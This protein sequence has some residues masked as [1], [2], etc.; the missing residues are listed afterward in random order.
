MAT[1]PNLI[2]AMD[3]APVSRFHSKAIFVSGMGFFTDAYD[4]FIIGT[5]STLISKQWHLGTSQ[6]ALINSMTLL[7]AFFGAIAWGRLADVVGRKR[8]YGLEAL[9]M[10]V[11]ALAS[12][13]APSFAALVAFRFVLGLGV[14][15]DY[16]VSAVLMSEYSNRADRGRLVG[17]VFAMQALG[18]VSGYVAGLALLAAGVD[19]E[20]V[21]RVLLGL[22]ALPSAA[23]L[24]SRR[25]MPESPRFQA[26]VLG[27]EREAVES[28]AAYSEGA[29]RAA[30]NGRALTAP[31]MTLGRFLTDR[32][33][34]LTL[35][36]T[37]GTW[38]VFDYAYYGNSVSAPLIVKTVLG[39]GATV[40]QS[41]ALNL[42]VF[43]VAA[44]PGYYLACAF[45]D[46]IGHRRLQLIGF[47]MMGVMFLLIGVIPGVTGV[48]AP[49]LLLFGAS[50]FFAEFGPNTTTFVLAAECFPTSVRTTG[51]GISAGVAKLGAFI[52]VY[53]FPH[54][55]K[56]FG[57]SGALEFSA[58]MAL[59][60]TVLTLAIPET[61][62]RSLEQISGE[63]S[64]AVPS[65]TV[66]QPE[67]A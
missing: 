1:G 2:Q 22:G 49:F 38:F 58:G 67:P 62:Q 61:S 12:A 40:E 7:G 55:T 29:V 4:L 53:L 18:T 14:G 16:P 39:K 44:V 28:L 42:I 41:L 32:R 63:I 59:I 21:W 36:G 11:F 64:L 48:V 35:L 9:I 10:L 65:G 26:W 13:A 37:A 25:R 17:L 60:G 46:R 57:V 15:G 20:V 30:T 3:E 6:T 50:Y 31:R 27:R 33:M 23:V 51:H 19:H 34:M 54:L 45:M 52:G 24:Y 47:P 8:I 43:S 66:L 56:A 5:A